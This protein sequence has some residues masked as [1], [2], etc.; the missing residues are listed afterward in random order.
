[1]ETAFDRFLPT[2]A[3][4]SLFILSIY[5]NFQCTINVTFVT[6]LNEGCTSKVL[7]AVYKEMLLLR[8]PGNLPPST[9]L[10]KIPISTSFTSVSKQS[11]C[12]LK[13]NNRFSK[14]LF[15]NGLELSFQIV[16]PHTEENCQISYATIPGMFL[17]RK[18]KTGSAVSGLV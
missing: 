14:T 17:R 3:N 6:T 15:Q 18:T 4:N 5:E 11:K 16:G 10:V 12:P 8:S 7:S 13:N 2:F 9:Q 1:M